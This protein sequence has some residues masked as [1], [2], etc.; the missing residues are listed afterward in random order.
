MRGGKMIPDSNFVIDRSYGVR[1]CTI[2]PLAVS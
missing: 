1:L 2:L